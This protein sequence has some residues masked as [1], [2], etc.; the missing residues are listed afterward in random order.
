M[1]GIYAG[2]RNTRAEFGRSAEAST[3]QAACLYAVACAST[4]VDVA[5]QS[6]VVAGLMATHYVGI[7]GLGS[8]MSTADTVSL[9]A[10]AMTC[11]TG[12]WADITSGASQDF[13]SPSRNDA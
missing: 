13:V 9:S 7:T 8:L 1:Y 5:A 10:A 12:L 6:A 4:A 11:I 2:I 3:S